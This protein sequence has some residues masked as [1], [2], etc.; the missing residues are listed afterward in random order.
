LQSEGPLCVG[1]LAERLGAKVEYSDR[2]S[3]ICRLV[4]SGCVIV[5][6]TPT[7][8]LNDAIVSL[9]ANDASTAR[10]II[11]FARMVKRIEDHP[12]RH[13]KDGEVDFHPGMKEVDLSGHRYE[14][15]DSSISESVL[16]KG[17]ES[18]ENYRVSFDS[19]RVSDGGLGLF[20][21]Q[22][23]NPERYYDIVRRMEVIAGLACLQPLKRDDLDR[24][25]KT[26]CVT[27]RQV[28]R[29]VKSYRE[30]GTS[31]L[32]PSP[33]RGGKGR[34][35]LKP[36]LEGIIGETIRKH[37]ETAQRKSVRATYNELKR[38]LDNVN[39]SLP[40]VERLEC[41]HE[42]TLY[43]RIN[44]IDPRR[45]VEKRDGIR[46][47]EE[48]FGVFGG[49]FPEGRFP[50]QT[51]EIDHTLSDIIL[52]DSV[53]RKPIGRPWLTAMI[54]AFSRC[55]SAYI[56]SLRHPNANT[57]GLTILMCATK[58]DYYV[59]RFGISEWPVVGIPW[60]VQ[61]D[62]GKDFRSR[63]IMAGCSTN[64]IQIMH[65]PVQDPKFGGG[66][67]RPFRT[68]EE[69]LVH[70]LPGTTKS[71]TKERGDYD[72]EKQACLTLD[73]FENLFVKFVDQYHHTKHA[74]LGMTPL[75]KWEQG[76]REHGKPRELA[77]QDEERFRISFLPIEERTLQKDGIHFEG[78][79]Y[80]SDKLRGLQRED[81]NSK[82]IKYIIRF[83]PSDLR[84]L[85][86]WNT[87][88]NSHYRIK[89]TT[90]SSVPIRLRE[91]ERARRELSRRGIGDPSAAIAFDQ[92]K[93]SQ[94]L[95][96]NAM[97]LTKKA[98]REAESAK[99][100]QEIK[101]HANSV[102]FQATEACQESVP[103]YEPPPRD[104]RSKIRVAFD[105]GRS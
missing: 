12:L 27:S 103:E 43:N 90:V 80:Y 74:E 38:A 23:N 102:S 30:R 32:I 21:L 101:N 67:E 42:R 63:L 56:L 68:F 18:G 9:M 62:N 20:A 71:S 60:Q 95:L 78:L 96:E 66:I 75:E 94:T 84:H 73:E 81:N 47:A 16:I 51:V 29:L 17:V 28:Q 13:M 76:I 64:G 34:H 54:D 1:S 65:R 93:K 89:S 41:P 57:N 33:R 59:A 2:C 100:E 58:K 3:T 14:V 22:V 92:Y 83:D 82:S 85:Y 45:R 79:T 36:V 77:P 72:S 8:Y 88:E 61:M 40:Q 10:F 7:P 49:K 25:A 69:S 31:G 11:P 86:V 99:R 91:W 19:I 37:Y 97:S 24:A 48:R 105:V 39:K 98:R 15:M 4:F 44:D 104:V 50:L 35:R 53:T 87:K 5:L 26:L 70:N 52:V 6:E 55:I 46:S